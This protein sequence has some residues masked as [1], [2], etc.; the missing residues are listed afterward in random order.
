VR[1]TIVVAMA[2]AIF[3]S[4]CSDGRKSVYPVHGK[5]V[6]AKNQPAI[7]AMLVF[8]PVNGDNNDS[9][10]PLGY[11]G[12]DGTFALTTYT[13]DDGAWEGE[14]QITVEW[15]PRPTTPFAAKKLAK[16]K[17]DGKYSNPATSKIRFKVEKKPDNEVPTIQLQ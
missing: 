14:Y 10:K 15:R 12:D 5:V 1:G 7:G 11:V 8:H 16:D 2:V 6:D 3:A 17:L 9:L 4:G 13:K